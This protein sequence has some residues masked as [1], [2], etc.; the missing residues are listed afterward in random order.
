MTSIYITTSNGI[1]VAEVN[2]E[3]RYELADTIST[4]GLG[5]GESYE[6][7]YDL[8]DEYNDIWGLIDEFERLLSGELSDEDL[9]DLSE[10]EY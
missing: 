10:Y 8:D 9:E 3:K 5:F 4:F 6:V 7:D 1:M 2:G